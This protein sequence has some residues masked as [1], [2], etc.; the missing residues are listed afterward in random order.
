VI[1]EAIVMSSDIARVLGWMMNPACGHY[2]VDDTWIE[3]GL[4]ARC[5][6]Y[7]HDVMVEHMQ[8]GIPYDPT[9]PGAG[10]KAVR[11]DTYTDALQPEKMNA[12]FIAWHDWR[13]DPAGLLS[14]AA[15]IRARIDSRL[16]T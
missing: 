15:K 5:I 6:A 8:F 2:K 12:D 11:D 4:A 10:M 1:P 13:K 9:D 7:R 14:D 3:L 16:M